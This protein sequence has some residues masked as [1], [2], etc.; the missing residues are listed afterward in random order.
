[1]TEPFEIRLSRTYA[2]EH[3]DTSSLPGTMIDIN[4]RGVLIRFTLGELHELRSRADYYADA[5]FAT[6]HG[7]RDLYRSAVKVVEQIK[8]A[9]LWELARSA[10]SS[11]AY[12]VEWVAM[13]SQADRE[14]A[15]YQAERAANAAR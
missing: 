2:L 11:A 6:E 5:D 7:M 10:E 1:M 13:R 4:G 15:E 12:D 14:W 9:G 3:L 8:R